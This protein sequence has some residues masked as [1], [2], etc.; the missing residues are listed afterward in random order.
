MQGADS[1]EKTLML[2]KI[3]ARRRRGQQR[4]RW[5]DGI[6]YSMDMGLGIRRPAARPARRRHCP[7]LLVL[8]LLLLLP[9]PPLLPLPQLLLRRLLAGPCWP[10][11][12]ATPAGLCSG[13]YGKGLGSWDCHCGVAGTG[14]PP[15]WTAAANPPGRPTGQPRALERSPG[16]C[17]C[18]GLP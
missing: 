16:H 14:R 1:L 18:W 3:E 11:G 2:G 12:P 6:S 13:G 17:S 10:Q 4:M 5:L 9:L 7:S 8:P 15:P